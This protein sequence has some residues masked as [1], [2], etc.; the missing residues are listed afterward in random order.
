MTHRTA[1]ITRMPVWQPFT[2][3]GTTYDLAHLDAFDHV[4][5]QDASADKPERRYA[6]RIHFGH[7]TFTEGRKPGDDLAMVYP[8]PSKDLRTFDVI[9]WEL[10]RQLP[11][12]IRSLMTRPVSHTGHENFFTVEV[13]TLGAEAVEYEVYFDVELDSSRRLQLVV[14]SAFPRDPSRISQRPHR[15]PM[16]FAVILHNIQLG[17]PIRTP[18]RSGRKH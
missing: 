7:H 16:R 11:A 5:V 12:I 8:A 4:Y 15:R 6:V 17:R 3:L 14:S 2:Y 10:S 13:T 1:T 9:R 18:P